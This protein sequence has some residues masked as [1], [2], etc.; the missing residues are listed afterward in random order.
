[1]DQIKDHPLYRKHNIDSAMSTLW[2]FYKTRFVVLFLVSLVMS[3]ILQ[4]ATVLVDFKEL[5]TITDPHIILEK[6]RR[7]I[8][9]MIIFSIV[10]LLFV[11]ILHHYILHKPLDSNNNIFISIYKSLRYFIP[12]LVIVVILAFVASIAMALGLL[13]LIIGIFFS[14]VYI[15]MISFFILPVMMVEEANIGNT[16]TR[17]IRLSHSNFWPNMGWTAI[18]IILYIIISVVLSGIVLI[19]FAGSFLKTFANPQDTSDI[20]QVTTNPLFLFLSSAVNALTLPLFPIFAYIIYFN[21]RAREDE[22]I[23]PRGDDDSN[24]RIAVEDLYAKP[25]PEDDQEIS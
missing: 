14:I 23:L 13:V 10:S 8:F 9:P 3:G 2:E 17:T 16:I 7:L 21:G 25:R 24:F 1:M 22:A 19:P 11:T 18:F 5:Q 4:Y 15:S 20:I 12:Y 6:L